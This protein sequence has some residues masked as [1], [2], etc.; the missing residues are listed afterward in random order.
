MALS[1]LLDLTARV[2]TAEPLIPTWNLHHPQGTQLTTS[3]EILA[4]LHAGSPRENDPLLLRLAELA[5]VDGGA[6]LDA[7][8]VLAK[9][10]LP[11]A[12]A[13]LRGLSRLRSRKVM[14]EHAAAVLWIACRTFPFRTRHWVATTISWQVY[15]N[16]LHELG[17]RGDGPTWAATVVAGD[18]AWWAD[19]TLTDEPDREPG[20]DLADLLAWARSN[21]VLSSEDES[22]LG[23]LLRTAGQRPTARVSRHGLL[24]GPVSR[25]VAV[26][27]GIGG[28]TVR[29]RVGLIVASLRDARP[30]YLTAMAS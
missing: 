9:L 6:S 19:E 23:I 15:R 5:H 29:R 20:D 10:V 13:R 8:A 14:E 7:A 11:G 28:S 25:A 24:S 21:G 16:T 3:D 26:E 30:A 27:C 18:T 4:A 22:L 2:A 17:D 12:A 1:E